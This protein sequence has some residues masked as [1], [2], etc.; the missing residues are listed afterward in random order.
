MKYLFSILIGIAGLAAGSMISFLAFLY[1]AAPARLPVPVA[2]IQ[3]P[4]IGTFFASRAEGAVIA[5]T[6]SSLTLRQQGE[7]M[8]VFDESAI[9]I[10]SWFSEIP[11][12]EPRQIAFSEVRVGD[13]VSGGVNIVND[14]ALFGGTHGEQKGD[15][16]AHRFSV[17]RHGK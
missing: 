5:R 6:D 7:D 16:I 14:P 8:T 12:E 9:G 10:S 4:V 11:N 2:S 17:V 1:Q 3:H 13:L 15:V